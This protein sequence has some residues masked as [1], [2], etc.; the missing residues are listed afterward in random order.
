M[1]PD[2]LSDPYDARKWLWDQMVA[3]Q[4]GYRDGMR[5]YSPAQSEHL[6]KPVAIKYLEQYLDGW[7][8]GFAHH[9]SP[10]YFDE[11]HSGE[12]D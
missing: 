4:D 12:T 10:G 8:A 11:P 1:P 3:F 7:K 6:A 9:G 5:A 2:E